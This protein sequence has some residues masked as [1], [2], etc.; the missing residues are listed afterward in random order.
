MR[1]RGL[2]LP[3]PQASPALPAIAGTRIRTRAEAEFLPSKSATKVAPFVRASKRMGGSGHFV[4]I[5]AGSI[6]LHNSYP[7]RVGDAARGRQRL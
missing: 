3:I 6:R 1:R 2:H 4:P 5:C 7:S